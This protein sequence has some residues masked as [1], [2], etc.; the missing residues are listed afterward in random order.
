MCKNCLLK[1]PKNATEVTI[2][3]SCVNQAVFTVHVVLHYFVDIFLWHFLQKETKKA[4]EDLEQCKNEIQEYEQ[5]ASQQQQQYASMEAQHSESIAELD[6][7]ISNLQDDIKEKE[8]KWEYYT[9]NI[10]PHQR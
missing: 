4:L 10:Q 9:P 2:F 8:N 3:W 5:L 6:E 1:Q 7:Q